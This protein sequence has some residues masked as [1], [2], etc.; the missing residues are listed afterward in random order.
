ME[1]ID[2]QTG[3]GGF[4]PGKREVYAASALAASLKQAAIGQALVRIIPEA[5]DFDIEH[6]NAFLYAQCKANKGLIPCPVVAPD[7]IGD[8]G[9]AEHQVQAAIAAGAG[10]AVLRPGP[11][12]WTAEPWVCKDIL[13][14]LG[15]HKLPAYT[16][17]RLIPVAQFARLAEAYPETTFIYAELNYRALRTYI[18]LMQEFPNVYLTIGCNFNFHAGF[19]LIA[20]KVGVDRLLFGSGLPVSEPCAAMSELIYSGLDKASITKIA[21]GNFKK[22]MKGI[23]K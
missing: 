17:E 8:L 6:S 15:K 5:N 1:F 4:T 21:S 16:A 2:V 11:D 18:P 3:F 9:G 12:Y 20:E 14:A 19:Q 23:R 13:T 10:A 7:A 22:L